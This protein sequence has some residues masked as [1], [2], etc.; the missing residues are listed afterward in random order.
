MLPK[1][2]VEDHVIRLRFEITYSLTISYCL[3]I[4]NKTMQYN[5]I[6]NICNEKIDALFLN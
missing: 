6:F 3:Y 5:K 1:L 4:S 2:L